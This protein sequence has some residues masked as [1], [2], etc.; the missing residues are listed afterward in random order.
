[1]YPYR[2]SGV[3]P[4]SEIYF[5]TIGTHTR[6]LFLYINCC[7]HYFCEYGYRVRRESM[8]SLLLI[9]VEKG[10]LRLDY[11]GIHYTIPQGDILLL[12]GSLPQYYDTAEYAEFFWMHFAGLNC[13]ELCA[14][15]TRTHG[16]VVYH[17]A[18]VS[19]LVHELVSQFATN[20]RINESEHSRLLY[21]ILC[22]LVSAAAPNNEAEYA[23]K[24]AVQQVVKYI[25][26]HLA[27]NL[28]L[29][30]IAA[31]VHLSQSH[32]IRLFRAELHYSPHEYIVLMRMDRAKYL[33]KSTDFPIKMIAS[34]V[35]YGSESSFIGAFTD[36]VGISPRKFRELPLG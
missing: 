7:G 27:E 3:L 16:S 31:E 33:L 1:M 35:G 25:Q 6:E 13:F 10:E 21:S 26:T 34:E 5:N 19:A 15:L 30:R 32:L 12:D 24:N 14:Y 2:E 4:G 28:S 11:Q 20:Q 23:E 29:K 22:Y 8:D 18:K 9:L 17:S 36:K